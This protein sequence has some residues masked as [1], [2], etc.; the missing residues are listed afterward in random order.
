MRTIYLFILLIAF[1]ASCYAHENDYFEVLDEELGNNIGNTRKITAIVER[2]T[3]KY[4]NT[5][6]K[7]YLI[8]SKFAKL[9]LHYSN[10]IELLSENYEIYTLNENEFP[11]VN[12]KV[13]YNLSQF[14]IDNPEKA[15]SFIDKGIKEA[16]KYNYSDYIANFYDIKGT[17]YY[18]IKDYKKAL[19]Y[20]N[21]GLMYFQK[22]KDI[23]GISYM[24]NNIGTVYYEL[25]KYDEAYS[26]FQKGLKVLESKKP[27]T[28]SEYFSLYTIKKSLASN[29]AKQGDFENAEKNYLEAYNYFK[30]IKED[31]VFR[32][33]LIKLLYDL[34]NEFSHQEKL[35]N[36]VSNIRAIEDSTVVTQNKLILVELLQDYYFKVNNKAESEVY[37]KKM[38]Q[39]NQQVHK[40]WYEQNKMVT[41]ILNKKILEDIDIK[42]KIEIE[43]HKKK[44]FWL[45]VTSFLLTLIFIILFLFIRNKRHKDKKLYEKE[46]EIVLQKKRLLQQDLELQNEK[47]KNLQLNLSLKSQT[48]K[49][50]L[51]RLKNM[52]KTQSNVDDVLKELY[53]NIHNLLEIDKKN[54]IALDENVIQN[55]EYIEKLKSRFPMLSDKELHLCVY[56]KL[57]LSSKE[58]A[59]LENTSNGSIRVLKSRIKTKI[60]LEKD[61]KLNEFL[62]T[63]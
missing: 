34:Y 59:I 5:G 26:V 55:K 47:V 36:L 13:Q 23:G 2:E 10:D 38:I 62:N 51:N 44:D 21:E 1:Q 61:D 37:I 63:I 24:Y 11:Y 7:K 45:F 6:E 15:N 32:V 20:Y 14:F 48:E 8:S 40:E 28:S 56:F 49:S 30:D 33:H 17:V 35:K 46:K 54:E 53:F 3:A 43:N 50:F 18:R 9:Y 31:E 39:L 52:R 27:F 42:N 41:D 58:I 19:K 57:N 29:Y 25:G 4:K 16:K 60:G 22:D 12:I